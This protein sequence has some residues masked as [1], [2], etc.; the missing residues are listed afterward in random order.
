MPY[1]QD[2]DNNE[3]YV[4]DSSNNDLIQDNRYAKDKHGQMYY[5]TDKD[6]NEFKD[7][8][9]GF[10]KREGVIILPI[11][12]Q[13]KP[14]YDV[15]SSTGNQI[16]SQDDGKYIIGYGRDG[17]QYYAKKANNDEY[18]PPDNTFAKK[19]D[20]CTYYAATANSETVFPKDKDNNEIY[21]GHVDFDNQHTI[22]TRY[23]RDKNQNEYYPKTI[24]ADSF[25]ADIIL[26]NM[27]ANKT[28]SNKFY[29]KDAF[30]NEF[31]LPEK[32]SRN[33]QI[34]ID[35]RLLQRYAVT[36][37][38]KIILPEVDNKAHVSTKAGFVGIV[39]LKDVLGRLVRE[40]RK[41]ADFLTSKVEVNAPGSDPREYKYQNVQKTIVTVSPP[42]S[43]KPVAKVS[44]TVISKGSCSAI[45]KPLYRTW[46]FWVFVIVSLIVKSFAVW[47]FFL[48]NKS[49]FYR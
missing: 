40:K 29:P 2:S 21:M 45:V 15:D 48:K 10:I 22:P 11:N 16:Y 23:A 5:P 35:D 42:Q 6:G 49:Y 38:K 39:E 30:N 8:H 44:P 17:H 41:L 7:V 18:Y 1:S 9:L 13:G 32:S 20:G 12:S 33:S 43:T 47:W 37:D 46:C 31:Y 27:Y 26:N 3:S 19:L 25:E 14:I 34:S 28:G 36:N 4:K 24:T